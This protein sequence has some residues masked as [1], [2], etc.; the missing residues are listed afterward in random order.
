M[1]KHTVIGYLHNILIAPECGLAAA[2]IDA[3]REAIKL[4]SNG[5]SIHIFSSGG[6]E[7]GVIDGYL[8]E[9][10]IQAAVRQFVVDALERAV[11]AGG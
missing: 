3:I 5:D 7:L 2:E 8:A 4:L 9:E 6:D 1:D 11:A 10:V